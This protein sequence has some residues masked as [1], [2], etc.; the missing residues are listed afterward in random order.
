MV[1]KETFRKTLWMFAVAVICSAACM[2]LHTDLASAASKKPTYTLTPSSKPYDKAILKAPSYNKKTKHWYMLN[3]YMQH[4]ESKKGGTLILKKGIYNL[5]ASVQVPSNVTFIFE[6]GVVINKTKSTGTNKIRANGHLFQLIPPSKVKKNYAVGK[7]NGSKNIV[8]QGSGNVVFNMNYYGPTGCCIIM[9]HNQNVSFSGISFKNGKGHFFELDA[10]DNVTIKDCSFSNIDNTKTTEAIN[11]DIPDKNR[12]GFSFRWSKFDRTPNKNITITDC[13]FE[14]M[15][16][17]IGSHGYSQTDDNVDKLHSNI[18]ITN[19]K[20]NKVEGYEGAI[21]PFNWKNVTIKNNSI[22][23]NGKNIT[24]TFAIVAHSVSD[25]KISNNTISNY[26]HTILIRRGFTNSGY[27][28]PQEV[29]ITSEQKELLSTNIYKPG[30]VQNP[31]AM[32]TF[33]PYY[34]SGTTMSY[35]KLRT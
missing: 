28:A 32:L 14:N 30:T 18:V 7:Y 31:D 16:R 26:E 27:Q 25:P 35:F 4:L 19:N 29:S 12:H 3:S 22:N 5:P 6:N 2:V 33:M 10:S 15:N 11:L 21:V 1:K 13:T 20:L 8:F 34:S 24:K 9:G 17:A 23:G